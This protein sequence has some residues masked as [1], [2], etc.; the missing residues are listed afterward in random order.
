M[1]PKE[2][3]EKIRKAINLVD[4]LSFRG[5]ESHQSGA[6]WKALCP[7]HSERTPSFHIRPEQQQWR[8]FGCGLG[9]D[10]FSLV[11]EMDQLSFYGAVQELA[12][13]AGIEIT[14]EE[15][16]E[17]KKLKR[18]YA[19]TGVASAW[20][21]E[22]FVNL[23]DEHPAKVN[24][25]ERKL[26]E[27]ANK[28]TTIGFAPNN[29]MTQYLGGKGF[30]MEEMKEVGLITS[31][32]RQGVLFRKRIIW[33]IK[34]IQGKV[35]GFTARKVYEA[36]LGGK[37]INSPQTKLYNKSH[38]L[39]GL[40]EAHKSITKSQSVYVVEGQTDVMALRAVG[41]ENVVAPNG[42][43]F[44]KEHSLM[45][46]RLADRGKDSKQFTI[47]FCFDGDAAGVNAA[48]KMFDVD[49]ILQTTAN[50]ISIPTGDPCDIRNLHGDD[51]L[52]RILEENKV[53]LLEFILK[54]ELEEWDIKTPEGQSKFIAQANNLLSGVDSPVLLESYKR[55]ISW[56]TGVPLSSI[57]ISGSRTA[58]R[59]A[60][61]AQAGISGAELRKRVIASLVQ[62]P[63]PTYDAVRIMGITSDMFQK[64]SKVIFEKA[65]DLISTQVM[66]G[67][68][69]QLRPDQFDNADL[70]SQLLF[71]VLTHEDSPSE[72]RIKSVTQ[73]ICRVFLSDYT[74]SEN[75]M[76]QA[77]ILGAT[78]DNNLVEDEDLLREILEARKSI[79][80]NHRRAVKK[81][82]KKKHSESD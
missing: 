65:I 50:V 23:P 43:A 63:E 7:I 34:N 71:T 30:S 61:I 80:V 59:K 54:K 77:R 20:F 74:S 75:N 38:S 48:K 78:D 5:V 6:T 12:D 51:V 39:F 70:I 81:P 32:D 66:K 69:V 58:A 45:L 68:K 46:Q 19:L 31:G 8:C 76:V 3:I 18:L 9:G 33:S 21:R 13:Y 49:P 41:I 79:P 16:A 36:D 62:F 17:F 52:I 29:G 22:N 11:Q 27:L 1:I 15:D 44:G 73:N 60:K 40:Y 55:K 47:N 14:E 24:F 56:W 42:T 25:S 26:L 53:T 64:E 67:E 57:S 4:Y 28:D 35:I 82:P 10:V 72:N 2:D 37:Y